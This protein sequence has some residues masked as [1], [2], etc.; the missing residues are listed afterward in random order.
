MEE[1]H[2]FLAKQN[3]VSIWISKGDEFQWIEISG[4]HE[5]RRKVFIAALAQKKGQDK[6]KKTRDYKF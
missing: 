2:R 1:M 3:Y 5:M 6:K 4:T